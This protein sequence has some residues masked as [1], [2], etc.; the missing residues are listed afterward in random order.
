MAPARRDPAQRFDR[1]HEGLTRPGGLFEAAVGG[2][3]SERLSRRGHAQ[4]LLTPPP[5]RCAGRASE[6]LSAHADCKRLQCGVPPE[7]S[8]FENVASNRVRLSPSFRNRRLL[9]ALRIVLGEPP[10]WGWV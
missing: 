3:A 1:E 2:E 4:S 5:G 10:R 9:N 6:C 8:E 7:P